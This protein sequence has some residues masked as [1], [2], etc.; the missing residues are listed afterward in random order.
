MI[1][2]DNTV[3]N[4][5]SVA[6]SRGALLTSTDLKTIFQVARPWDHMSFLM[7]KNSKI[8]KRYTIT[9]DAIGRRRTQCYWYMD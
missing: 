5:I 4:A 7:S 9:T 6:L 1:H 3:S 8:N 2:R